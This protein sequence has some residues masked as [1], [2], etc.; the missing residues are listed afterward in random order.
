MCA[1]GDDAV[2]TLEQQLA[3]LMPVGRAAAAVEGGA[4]AG[5]AA[6]GHAAHSTLSAAMQRRIHHNIQVRSL[7]LCVPAC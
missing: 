7:R 1:T 3:G 6:D 2:L 5:A 4:A